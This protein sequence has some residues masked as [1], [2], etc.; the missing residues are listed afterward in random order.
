[1]KKIIFFISIISLFQEIKAQAPNW[2]W[3]NSAGGTNN[4][5]AYSITTDLWGNV[6][7]VG[8]FASSPMNFGSTTLS[9]V[10]AF[11]VFIVKYNTNGNVLWA[12]SAGG[13]SDD[14][15]SSVT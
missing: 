9:A 3:A 2:L 11:D 13:N 7:A 5:Q 10:G 6:Y 8:I 4:D 15:A 12:K 1:M 14:Y